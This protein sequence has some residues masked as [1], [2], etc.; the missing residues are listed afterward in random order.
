VAHTGWLYPAVALLAGGWLIVESVQLLRRARR[1]LTEAALKPMRL[2][3]LSNSY[4]AV[5]FLAAAV[6]PLIF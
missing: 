1:G 5:V 4:L 6:D 2:F 3:H